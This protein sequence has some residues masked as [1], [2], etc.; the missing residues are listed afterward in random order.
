MNIMDNDSI[1]DK[2]KHITPFYITNADYIKK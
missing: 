2:L 1:N